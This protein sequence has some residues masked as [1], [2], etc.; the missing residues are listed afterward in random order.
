LL[1]ALAERG[2]LGIE[3]LHGLGEPQMRE[4]LE[5][6]ARAAAMTCGRRGADLPYRRELG[7]A[8]SQR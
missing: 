5:F 6:A 2:A 8:P 1:T 3:A 4:A 7:S